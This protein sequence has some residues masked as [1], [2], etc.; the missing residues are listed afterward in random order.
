MSLQYCVDLLTNREPKKGFE[1]VIRMK[2]VLHQERMDEIVEDD[3][4]ELPR[5]A[6]N[7]ALVTIRKKGE[8]KY[9]FITNAGFSLNE[10][11]YNL[12]NI[13]WKNEKIPDSWRES[14]LVQL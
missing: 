13:I 12:Y 10:A 7:K 1:E 3:I 4:D 2:E 11:L 9:K 14:T 6:F 5:E 8:N